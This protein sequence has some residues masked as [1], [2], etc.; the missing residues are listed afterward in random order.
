MPSWTA[1]ETEEFGPA[2][3]YQNADPD[4]AAVRVLATLERARMLMRLERVRAALPSNGLP[5]GV[6]TATT[7]LVR[8]QRDAD[9]RCRFGAQ[10]TALEKTAAIST[11]DGASVLVRNG[12]TTPVFVY[13]FALDDS[14]ML[15]PLGNACRQNA[16]NRVDIGATRSVDLQ[17]RNGSITP[18]LAPRSRNGVMV[19]LVPFVPGVALPLDPCRFVRAMTDSSRSADGIEDPIAGMF[20]ARGDTRNAAGPSSIGQ[21]VMAV[22]TWPVDQ[23]SQK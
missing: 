14:W 19:F 20:L 16:Q 3:A 17:Y 2:V 18:G 7:S 11:C 15:H 22:E 5:I 9:G 6:A 23:G 4:E 12:G 10:R 13:V 8:Y 1:P 21:L